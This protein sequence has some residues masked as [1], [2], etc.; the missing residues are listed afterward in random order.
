M[1][2]DIVAE[3][4]QGRPVLLAE[5]RAKVLDDE[6]ARSML[7]PM[8][9][10]YL[11]VR[12]GL[13][14]DLQRIR[15]A[16]FER[17]GDNFVCVLDTAEMLREYDREFGTKRIFG[18]YLRTL[19]EAWLRD[20]VYHWNSETPPGSDRLKEIGLAQCLADGDTRS[21]VPVGPDPLR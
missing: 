8:R 15:I 19:V 12:F 5:V 11:P 3:D 10:T 4:A 9:D 13:V 6:A 7:Q 14:A 2:F 16:D 1:R 21:E 17:G 20:H 18:H